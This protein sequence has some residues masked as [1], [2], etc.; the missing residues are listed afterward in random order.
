MSRPSE[1]RPALDLWLARLFDDKD[2]TRFGSG[3]AS[4]TIA[5]FLGVLS[6]GAVACFHLPATLTSPQVRAV[7]ALSWIRPLVATIIGAAFFF[8]LLSTLLRR[9]KVLGFTGMALALIASIMGGASVPV[10]GVAGDGLGLGLDWF[11]LNLLLLALV[12]VPMERA[13]AQ[14]P[15]QST[16]RPGWTTDVLHFFMSH[17]LVQVSAWLTLAPA[18]AATR[19]F[20]AP[21]LQ[22]TVALLP[23]LFQ[24]LLVILVADLGEY[25]M[26]R[27]FHRVPWLWRF[28]AIHHSSEDIDWLAGSRLHLVD[29]VLTRGFTFVPISLLGF[30][31]GP[32]Y[33]YLV[34][35]SFHAVFIHA[36]VRFRFGR[37]EH[38]I[39]TPRFHHWH[40]SA[41]AEA[42]DKNFAVHLPW[43]DR[44]L[45]TYYC[46]DDRWP[47]RY[48]L[49]GVRVRDSYWSHLI[50]PLRGGK[51]QS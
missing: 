35:V 47:E 18:A 11:L 20:V 42:L 43:I 16:F 1:N 27:L 31:N 32:V 50:W 6:V 36:N 46:P 15:A 37:V 45:G 9:R 2:E 25:T 3:W 38:L 8:G 21:Q 7:Y 12:F 49:S 51:S 30:A 39:V 10:T 13:F 19:V 4:G 28:H 40:H 14:R 41:E 33:A 34:F 24:F 22:A 17:L 44:V 23:W 48:G 5:V 29:V 26:H